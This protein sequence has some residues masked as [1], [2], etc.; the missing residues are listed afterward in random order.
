MRS[1]GTIAPM[2]HEALVLVSYGNRGVIEFTDGTQS[3]CLYRRSVGRPYCGDRV[4]VECVD[5]QST[6]VTEILTRSN[7]FARANA[8]QQKQVIA[9]N[10]D[11]VLIV[12]AAAPEPSTDLVE[13]YLVAVHSLGI[14][15]VIVLNKCEMTGEIDLAA[16]SPLHHL[17]D[18]RELGYEVL[19]TSCKGTPGIDAML[20]VLGDKT[21]I[22]VGQSGVGKS[23]LVNE[24]LPDLD[25]QTGALSRV[26]GKGIHTTTTTIMYSLLCGGRL[27]DS[28]GVWEYGLW[29]MDQPE[30]AG[31][32]V[33]F[34]PFLG[35]CR[36]NDCR[37][38][39]E[40]DCAVEEAVNV[41]G[42]R[43]WRYES[44][45]RLLEQGS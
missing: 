33:E 6:V 14:R 23:S 19:A 18:Y 1:T 45:R 13:R 5:G 20:P 25:L 40:P 41:G 7:E 37:H 34:H 30:L 29:E 12:I 26:T 38:A 17:D 32:F 3:D 8:R 28:P 27:I 10:L 2:N 16:N 9:A 39:D 24:L 36:F 44:Y 15:P 22:L 4:V 42:I 21:S 11:Q 35:H 31:G 43:K